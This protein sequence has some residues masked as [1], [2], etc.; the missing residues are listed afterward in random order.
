MIKAYVFDAYGTLFD[1]HSAV[2]PH[3]S[4]IGPNGSQLS[5]IW[6][7]KQLEYTW[8]MTLNGSYENFESITAQALDFAMAKCAI[9]DKA[10]RADLLAA[11]D[12]LSAYEEVG[13]ALKNI[14]DTGAKLAILSNGTDR[15]LKAATQ[16]ARLADIFDAIFSV[17]VIKRFKPSRDVYALASDGLGLHPSEI[18]FQSSN[19][20]DIAGAAHFGFKTVWINRTGQPNEYPAFEPDRTI[21]S[22]EALL[23]GN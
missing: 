8:V 5:E 13:K 20:W 23:T 15:M 14:K 3:L 22:L 9:E 7:T 21:D 19:R 16:S 11:Y 18:S 10:L 6:R 2:R 1:V 17:D 12:R 4:K